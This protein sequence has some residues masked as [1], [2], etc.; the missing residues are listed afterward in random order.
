MSDSAP[1]QGKTIL[2]PRGKGQAKPFSDLVRQYGGVPVEIPLI[3]F[4][5]VPKNDELMEIINKLSTYDW[6]IFTSNVTIETFFKIAGD[7]AFSLLPKVA[8][9]GVRTKQILEDRGIPV[10]FTPSE[11]VAEGFLREFMPLVHPGMKVLIPKGNLARDI[12]ATTLSE[13]GAIVTESIIYETYA[14]EDS[15]SK[16]VEM[17]K[18]NELNVLAFTSPS[19]I[20]HFMEIVT[21]SNLE[22]KL[23]SCLVACIGPVS[24]LKAQE[25]GLT[26]HVSPANYTIKDMLLALIDLLNQRTT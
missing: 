21:E 6:I 3:A 15:K 5:P 13:A 11:Y 14:P 18:K 25:L 12:I 20:D 1:L 7:K 22:D 19:T 24:T 9:I 17:L 8:V 23:H 26:V 10:E 4:R 16:L 2:V